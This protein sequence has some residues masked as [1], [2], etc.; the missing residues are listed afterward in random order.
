MVLTL[1]C[2]R[3]D[4]KSGGA[5]DELSKPTWVNRGMLTL[6]DHMDSKEGKG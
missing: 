2:L 3:K 5:H 6:M 4:Y 1:L